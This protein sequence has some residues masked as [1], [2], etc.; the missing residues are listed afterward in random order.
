MPEPELLVSLSVPG[1]RR[2]RPV[3]LEMNVVFA[4]CGPLR[5]LERAA[6]AALEA[7]EHV[8]DVLCRHRSVHALD[9]ADGT[10]A[11]RDGRVQVGADLH[12]P[13]AAD[14]LRHVHPVRA[15]VAD[16]AERAALL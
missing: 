7:D 10:A 9:L 14:E 16:R 12:D 4:S 3:D 11:N 15:D 8:A 5:D 13:P 1:K 6:R 2:L